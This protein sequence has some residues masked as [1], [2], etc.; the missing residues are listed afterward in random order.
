MVLRARAAKEM[1]EQTTEDKPKAIKGVPWAPAGV[2]QGDGS[3][4]HAT[5][6]TTLPVDNAE[7][8]APRNTKIT[9]KILLKYGAVG[10]PMSRTTGTSRKGRRTTPRP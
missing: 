6:S 3:T 10:E 8:S 1:P 5:S 9:R 4:P 7:T 2:M